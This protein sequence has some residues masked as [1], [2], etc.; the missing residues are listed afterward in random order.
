[1]KI[2]YK[3]IRC[4]LSCSILILSY[5]FFFKTEFY[6]L[7]EPPKYNNYIQTTGVLSKIIRPYLT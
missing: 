1:M 7:N 2:P 6:E 3:L 5:N 4:L